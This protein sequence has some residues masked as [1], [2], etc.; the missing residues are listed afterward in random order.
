MTQIIEKL[1]NHLPLIGFI[2]H[3][4]GAIFGFVQSIVILYLVVFIFKFGCNLFGFGVEPSLADDVMNIP[5]L[6]EKFGNS[7]EAFDDIVTL[8][9][10]NEEMSKEEFNN[11]AIK[12]LL[13]KKVI[14]R[15]N[16]NVLIDKNKITYEE[17]TEN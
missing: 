13:D 1:V 15:E 12:V 7:L 3:L 2:D 5:I 14:S 6:K 10:D 11:R 17:P 4:I 9:A 8:K 16:L